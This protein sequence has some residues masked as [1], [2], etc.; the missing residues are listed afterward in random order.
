MHYQTQ[1][2]VEVAYKAL[3]KDI[4]ERTLIPGKKIVLREL[5]ERYGISETPIKQALNRLITEGLVESIPRKGMKVKSIKWEEIEELLDIRFMIETYYIKQAIQIFKKDSD[6]KE[7]FLKNLTEH[8]QIIENVA[9]VNDYFQNYYLDQEFHQ[10]FIKCSGN[11]KILQIYNN[12]GTHTYAYYVYGRQD[13]AGMI[14][15]V[16]EHEAIYNALVAQDEAEL[17]KCI[18]IHM[19]N[20]KNNI[21]T[22]FQSVKGN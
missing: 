4:T 12:L 22:M 2:L 11:K 20:A 16:K 13:R 19:I 3:K 21:Y 5:S 1:T 7:K 10:L 14:A 15:G 8:K 17:R 6:I 9:D 18:E